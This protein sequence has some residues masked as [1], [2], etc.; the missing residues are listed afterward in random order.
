ML[1]HL[2]EALLSPKGDTQYLLQISTEIFKSV[3]DLV[4]RKCR[5][6][7]TLFRHGPAHKIYEN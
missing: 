6:F 7:K 4:R 3:R 5:D 1:V 2:S